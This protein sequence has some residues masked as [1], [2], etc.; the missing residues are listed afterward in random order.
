MEGATMNDLERD[1]L[2]LTLKKDSRQTIESLIQIKTVLK[3]YNGEGLV[4]KVNN[5]G[6]AINKLWI[7]V[8]ILSVSIGG[9]VYGILQNLLR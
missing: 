9:G 7:I 5:N 1:S 8:A 2:L 4:E 3:G 6:K